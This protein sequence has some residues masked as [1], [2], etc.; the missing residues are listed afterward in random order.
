MA[1]MYRR[2]NTADRQGHPIPSHAIAHRLTY[3]RDQH[4]EDHPSADQDD[5][6]Q[7]EEAAEG[8]E[9]VH[10]GEIQQYGQ[11]RPCVDG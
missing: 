5:L 8:K 9:L 6:G 2:L 11:S 1:S 10:T 3:L 4:D 7:E